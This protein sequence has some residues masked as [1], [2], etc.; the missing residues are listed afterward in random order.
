MNIC[1]SRE[2]NLVGFELKIGNIWIKLTFE[3]D[4]NEWIGCCEMLPVGKLISL[5]V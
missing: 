1:D 2:M 4:W 5:N 3:F